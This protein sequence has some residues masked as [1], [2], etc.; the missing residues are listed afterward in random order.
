MTAR[1]MTVGE[2]AELVGGEVT[3]DA[4]IVVCGAAVLE[5]SRSRAK[6]RSS[7]NSSE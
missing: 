4:T 1:P 7:I 2:L 3:G 5:R 6:S